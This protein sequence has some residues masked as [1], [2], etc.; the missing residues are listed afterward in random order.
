MPRNLCSIAGQ[1]DYEAA[2]RKAA[3]ASTEVAGQVLDISNPAVAR[4]RQ[5]HGPAARNTVQACM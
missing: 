3:M 2:A 5:A 1:L 4:V